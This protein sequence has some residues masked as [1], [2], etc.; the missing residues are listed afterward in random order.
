M[1]MPNKRLM[2]TLTVEPEMALWIDAQLA[3]GIPLA[4]LLRMAVLGMMAAEKRKP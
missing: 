2:V 3:K 4:R 1:A